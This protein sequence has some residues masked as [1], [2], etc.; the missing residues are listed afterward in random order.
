MDAPVLTASTVT[1]QSLDSLAVS[2]AWVVEDLQRSVPA[3]SNSSPAVYH[4]PLQE[5]SLIFNDLQQQQDLNERLKRD[6]ER[7]KNREQLLNKVCMTFAG[8]LQR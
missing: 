6:V 1:A 5:R 2:A 8:R 4:V 7:F 3:L